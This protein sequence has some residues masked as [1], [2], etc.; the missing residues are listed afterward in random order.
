MS[1]QAG[2]IDS[3]DLRPEASLRFWME[4][5]RRVLYLLAA[6][7]VLNFLDL[8]LTL[9]ESG[10]RLFRELNPVAARMMDEPLA[11]VMYKAS[12]VWI[13]SWILL[14]FRDRRLTEMACWFLLATY[15][16]VGLRWQQYYTDVLV[17]FHDPCVVFETQACCAVP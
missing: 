7:W 14:R 11:L 12:L 9:T 15:S 8:G 3:A 4:R 17:T 6:V 10:A 1:L 5:P 13:G 16:Y 2:A